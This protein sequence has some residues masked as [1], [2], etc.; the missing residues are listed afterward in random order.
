MDEHA[1]AREEAACAATA[2]VV[3]ARDRA[4]AEA[5]LAALAMSDA[6]RMLV[7]MSLGL[8]RRDTRAM[9]L[10]K[11][12]H[13][14]ALTDDAAAGVGMARALEAFW[15]GEGQRDERYRPLARVELGSALTTQAR[16]LARLG[17]LARVAGLVQAHPGLHD[18][19]GSL[20][21]VAAEALARARRLDE[22]RAM[23]PPQ[24]PD[25]LA[26]ATGWDVVDG[27]L[28]PLAL[29]GGDEDG[30][31]DGADLDLAGRWSRALDK[32]RQALDQVCGLLGLPPEI[33]AG[34][35][36]RLE[37]ERA[38]P[39]RTE[40]EFIRRVDA[41]RAALLPSPGGPPRAPAA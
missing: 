37:Q 16:G 3:T 40:A 17:E 36:A 11:A 18:R 34:L 25:D 9:M 21:I 28:E 5:A 4:D 23:L 14:S 41:L 10:G 13:S 8:D 39:P 6:D 29:D 20:A 33:A 2:R 22:A 15:T 7:A 32:V 38:A 19:H 26:D 35:A 31:E 1:R 12:A 24:R 27:L 30:D